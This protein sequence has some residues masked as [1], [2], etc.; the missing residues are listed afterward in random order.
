MNIE[1]NKKLFEIL[2]NVEWDKAIFT[3]QY[4]KSGSSNP[5]IMF[6]YQNELNPLGGFGV[7]DI[8]EIIDEK[9]NK[10][11]N[12]QVNRFN[13]VEIEVFSNGKQNEKF[14]WDEEKE[15]LDK[16]N[17][18]NVFYQWI[19]DKMIMSIFE[20]EQKNDMI[21]TYIDDDGELQYDNSWD[22]GVF[23]FKIKGGKLNTYIKLT[24]DLKERVLLMPI[25]NEFEKAF[26]EHF[27]ITNEELKDDWEKWNVLE[28]KSPH[29]SIPYD[30]FDEYIS[31]TYDD[32]LT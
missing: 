23:V 32:L 12:D 13:K 29:N 30:T 4:S 6:S 20:Y 9:Y 16:L 5:K 14:W 8:S 11:I 26:L 10:L 24:K 19:N 22:N 17:T 21:P 18:A 31:Y 25:S 3:T 2:E 15:K 1:I 7:F 27:R 28:V